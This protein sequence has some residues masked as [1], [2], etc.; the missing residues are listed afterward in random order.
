MYNYIWNSVAH[1]LACIPRKCFQFVTI[2]LYIFI[3]YTLVHVLHLDACPN[4]FYMYYSYCI[5]MEFKRWLIIEIFLFCSMMLITFS[6]Y[7]YSIICLLSAMRIYKYNKVVSAIYGYR[8]HNTSRIVKAIK[9]YIFG[10]TIYPRSI[11]SN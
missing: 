4:N 11:A 7:V 9:T 10:Q 1:L 6:F 5:F 8:L 3:F 2:N